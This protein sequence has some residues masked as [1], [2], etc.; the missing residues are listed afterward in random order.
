MHVCVYVWFGCMNGVQC[1]YVCWAVCV[2]VCVLSTS[3][4]SCLSSFSPTC[5]HILSLNLCG[6]ISSN[7]HLK[8]CVFQMGVWN[9]CNCARDSVQAYVV[10]VSNEF[11]TDV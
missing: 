6:N 10:W 8:L 7:V 11:Q 4:F 3:P 2:C 9:G 5:T 1:L